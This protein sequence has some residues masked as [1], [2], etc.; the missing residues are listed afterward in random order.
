MCKLAFSSLTA[1]SL[2]TSIGT[3][4][5]RIAISPMRIYEAIATD[6]TQVFEGSWVHV[7]LTDKILKTVLP[8]TAA[9]LHHAYTYPR[10]PE[11]PF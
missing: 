1:G 6:L 5:V 3:R 9:K 8:P 2:Y 4:S 7:P 11:S 10:V